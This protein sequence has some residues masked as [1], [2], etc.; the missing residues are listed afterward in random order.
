MVKSFL[1]YMA[2]QSGQAELPKLGYS[3]LPDTLATKVRSAVDSL[4]AA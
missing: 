1:T 2:S 3:Q 4:T